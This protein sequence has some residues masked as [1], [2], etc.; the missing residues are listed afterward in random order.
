MPNLLP[1][2]KK[3]SRIVGEIPT[4]L[5]NM[6]KLSWIVWKIPTTTKHEKAFLGRVEEFASDMELVGVFPR[7]LRFAPSLTT[8]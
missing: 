1:K 7:V 2:I 6:K 8:G 4:L 5:P 3:C